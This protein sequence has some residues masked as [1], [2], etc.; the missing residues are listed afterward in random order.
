[1]PQFTRSSDTSVTWAVGIFF[2]VLYLHLAIVT[3]L[4]LLRFVSILTICAYTIGV[5]SRVV[6][7]LKVHLR[8]EA[9][10]HASLILRL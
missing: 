5:Y 6:E 3:P 1:M 2:Q 9:K 8:L 4:L 10:L 7:I